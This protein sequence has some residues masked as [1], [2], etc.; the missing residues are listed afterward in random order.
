MGVPATTGQLRT[1][2]SDMKIGDYIYCSYIGGSTGPNT[3]STT[4]WNLNTTKTEI[5][6]AGEATPNGGFYFVKTS[7]GLLVADR[8]V[9]HTVTWD[10]LNSGKWIQGNPI[11]FGNIIPVMTSNTAPSGVAS[12]S[13]VYTTNYDPFR[14]FDKNS[15]TDTLRW[16]SAGGVTSAWLQYDFGANNG[17]VVTRYG[18]ISGLQA[19]AAPKAWTFEGSNTGDFTGEQVILDSQTGQTGW[20]S[21]KRRFDIKSSG[22]YRFYRINI[23]ENNGNASY[24]AQIEE[25]EMYETAGIIRSLTGGVAYADANG[26]KV[27][28]AP[29]PQLGAW[30]TNNEWDKFVSNF[31]LVQSGKTLDDVFHHV[32]AS[33]LCTWCQETPV[34][35]IAA[36]TTRVARGRLDGIKLT[37]NTSSYSGVDYG[38]RPV[39]EYKE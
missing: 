37:T 39:F 33:G 26:D 29:S 9:N 36:N 28:T 14:A 25:L 7:K 30:P 31:S 12:A 38:F 21:T 4:Q 8:V 35:A 10:T 11:D 19:S 3:V 20:T 18:I 32:Q 16:L 13:S 27:T 22:S 24:F 23:T 5:S 2:V 34:L 17:K 15:G 1:K 6:V